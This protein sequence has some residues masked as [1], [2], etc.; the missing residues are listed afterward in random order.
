MRMYCGIHENVSGR[1]QSGVQT[2]PSFL[3]PL[4]ALSMTRENPHHQGIQEYINTGIQENEGAA[5]AHIAH[6]TYADETS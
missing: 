3:L 5:E 2:A 1:T 6:I 4:T